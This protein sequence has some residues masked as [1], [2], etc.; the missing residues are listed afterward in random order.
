MVTEQQIP[1]T[2]AG[3]TL[4]RT[5]PRTEK[6]TRPCPA[7]AETAAHS[8]GIKNELEIVCC[9]SCATFYTP[10]SPWYTSELYYQNFYAPGW[11][12]EPEFVHQRAVEITARFSEYRETN[13]FLDIGCGAGTL[14]EAARDDGWLARGVDVSETSV[15]R[16]RDRG[17]E[18]FH[19]EVQ[20][21]RYPE[22]HFDVITAV[23]LLEHLSD[24]K[25]VVEEAARLLR[26]GGAFWTT[27][28]H[29]RGIS[30]RLL[31]IKWS[32]NSPPE[33]LQLFSTSGL[34]TLFQRAGF[35]EITIRTE[36][37]NPLEI[38]RGFKSKR[39]RAAT[40]YTNHDRVQQTQNLNQSLTRTRSRRVIKQ[41]A[42]GCLNL[43]GMGD[44]LKVLALR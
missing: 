15:A 39:Q 21:A 34:K 31:G 6:S 20:E 26:K 5:D 24:P 33:H 28:P 38:V 23:E 2:F 43:I 44:S 18:V 32:I 13:R 22:A 8:V 12:S 19:G 1:D 11:F 37:T 35:R 42:N 14:L 41:V 27:T 10:Y 29:G 7:C 3:Q 16:M 36:G 30:A 25:V 4:L 9:R 40:P 17:F